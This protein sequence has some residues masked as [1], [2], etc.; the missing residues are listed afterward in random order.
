[1]LHEYVQS[2]IVKQVVSV[3]VKKEE[4]AEQANSQGLDGLKIAVVTKCLFPIAK[5]YS[6]IEKL[7]GLTKHRLVSDFVKEV[8]KRASHLEADLDTENEQTK[9]EVVDDK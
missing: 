2:L 8:Q 1:M 3:V 4:G 5:T 6:E 9:E 7:L